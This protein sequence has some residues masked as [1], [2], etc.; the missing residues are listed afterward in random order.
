M[1]KIKCIADCND[2]IQV[3]DLNGFCSLIVGEVEITLMQDGEM[4]SIILNKK[5]VTKLIKQLQR[6]L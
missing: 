6:T 5:K 4:K 2:Y 1:K 3:E